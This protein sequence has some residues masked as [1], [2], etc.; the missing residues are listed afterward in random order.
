MS[1][2]TIP[3]PEPP[4]ETTPVVAPDAAPYVPPPPP[5]P[6]APPGP[7]PVETARVQ[8]RNANK[9]GG[10][11]AVAVIAVAIIVAI[12]IAVVVHKTAKM[13]VDGTFQ[14]IGLHNADCTGIEGYTDIGP[15]TQVTISAD[16]KILAVTDL[17]PAG[18]SSVS[19]MCLWAF[20]LD[21]VE[22]NHSVYTVEVAHRGGISFTKAQVEA[23]EVGLTLGG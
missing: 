8:A 12:V 14:F 19:G 22:K 2:A 10:L 3:S 1:D 20:T 5:A 17:G 16:G 13:S 4:D 9:R 18:N 23:G 11:I 6:P 7:D 15:N 21:G